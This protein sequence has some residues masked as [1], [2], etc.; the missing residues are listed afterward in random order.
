MGTEELSRII[1]KVCGPILIVIAPISLL[2]FGH[3]LIMKTSVDVPTVRDIA[4]IFSFTIAGLALGI[5]MCRKEYG[6]FKRK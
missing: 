6:W 2:V 1:S 5:Y 3:A 4:I